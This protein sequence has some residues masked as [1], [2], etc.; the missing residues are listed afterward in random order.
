MAVRV[1]TTQRQIVNRSWL[2]SRSESCAARTVLAAAGGCSPVDR[3]AS[4]WMCPCAGTAAPAPV[5][6]VTVGP[7]RWSARS[8]PLSA[9]G[10]CRPSPDLHAEATSADRNRR[11]LMPRHRIGSLLLQRF[12]PGL[13]APLAGVGRVPPDHRDTAAGR[14]GG[15]AVAGILGGGTRPRPAATLSPHAPAPG[16]PPRGAGAR[17]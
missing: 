4:W 14:H 3:H 12:H 7:G 16:P 1:S 8:G 6:A 9:A 13:G 15:E 2:V 17:G 10:S 11:G 5:A